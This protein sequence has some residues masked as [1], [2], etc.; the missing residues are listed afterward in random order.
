MNYL[1]LLFYISQK[2]IDKITLT[3]YWVM[4]TLSTSQ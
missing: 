2:T 3:E 4:Y 1:L